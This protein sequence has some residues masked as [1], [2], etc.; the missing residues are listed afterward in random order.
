MTRL[1]LRWLGAEAPYLNTPTIQTCGPLSLGCYGGTTAAG[2]NKNEDAA[3]LWV[4]AQR[5]WEWALLCDAHHSADS[6]A[7]L[8]ECFGTEETFFRSILDQPTDKALA[9]IET[10]V[11]E[12]MRSPL[13]RVRCAEINGEASCLL[14]V[15]HGSY[16]WWLSIGD[17]LA[18]LLHPVLTHYGQFGLNQ[19][20]F[21]QW[22]GR[23]NTFD[24]SV[25]CRSSGI[26]QLQAGRN[27][28]LLITD[29]LLEFGSQPFMNNQMLYAVFSARES[30]DERLMMALNMVKSEHGVDSASVVAWEF[31][32]AAIY[33][34]LPED[35]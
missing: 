4:D 34:P 23:A 9:Q 1:S 12:V 13:M 22:I 18:Y 15:R 10:A 19:R 20:V 26:Q 30:L 8:L 28:L 21:Y 31:D 35:G 17:C 6:A 14:L 33:D 32:P 25:P 7:L 27:T 11:L 2:A 16:L 5:R 29:G 3:L 24:R